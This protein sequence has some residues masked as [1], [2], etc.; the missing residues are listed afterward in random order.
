M[1]DFILIIIGIATFT[2]AL[3]AF[4]SSV[5][6][7]FKQG[8][9]VEFGFL[10][11][12]KIVQYLELATGDPAKP[13]ILRFRN[14]GKSTLTGIVIDLRFYR[15]LTLSGTE[16]A[17]SVIPGK[18][19]HGRPPDNRYYHIRYSELEMPGDE[20]M[21]FRVEL[22]TEK[23]VPGTYRVCATVYSTQQDYKYKKV[24]LSIQLK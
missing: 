15:P 3:L 13:L 5:T 10:I 1:T 24:D 12:D 23:K 16:Q 11:D 4:L 6:S 21:D 14:I 20:S 8:I 22:S 17:L 18:T 7:W 9:P 19:I 2:V